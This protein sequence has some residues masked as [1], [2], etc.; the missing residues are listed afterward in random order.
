MGNPFG[1]ASAGGTQGD[2]GGSGGLAE[3][4]LR[5]PAS[6]ARHLPAV[7]KNGVSLHADRECG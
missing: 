5:S 6:D 4:G 3:G 2:G 1:E 7:G